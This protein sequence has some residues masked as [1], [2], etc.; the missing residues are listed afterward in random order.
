[1][2]KAMRAV[3]RRYLADT[4]HL[5][6]DW[7][8]VHEYPLTRDVRA[9]S[10]VWRST[11]GKEYVVAAKGAPE[12][13]A[14]L[15]HLDSTAAAMLAQQVEQLTA[16]GCACSAWRTRASKETLGRRSSTISMF[17]L[18]GLIARSMPQCRLLLILAV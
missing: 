6:E 11:G 13:I 12:A 4:E 9:I 15:C 10:Y 1:M 8:L 2:E 3:G 18:L 14:D 16:Q 5:H 7:Q 17:R